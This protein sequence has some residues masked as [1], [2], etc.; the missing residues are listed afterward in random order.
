MTVTGTRVEAV[1]EGTLAE[2]AEA[3]LGELVTPASEQYDQ[4]RS[5]WNGAH[6]R[7][8]AVIIRCAGV[9]DVVRGVEFA[10]SEGL[11]LAV[12]GGGHSIPG[13]STT[14]GGVVL[15]LSAMK[16]VRVDP[17]SRRAVA[18]AGCLWSDIDHETQAFDS[19]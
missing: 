12:R 4:P 2:L 1:G 5:I 9:S 19:R 15:D 17:T 10:R 18:Q 7:R 16:G 11:P 6:D 13:F 14:D 3:L 8:P